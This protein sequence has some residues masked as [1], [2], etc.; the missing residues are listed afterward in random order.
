MF[1]ECSD[2]VQYM[3]S[4]VQQMFSE[5]SVGVQIM[6]SECSVSVQQMHR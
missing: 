1:S 4:D 3:L 2:N 5:C 6:F